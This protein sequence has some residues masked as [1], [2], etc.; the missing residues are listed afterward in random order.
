MAE[1][2]HAELRKARESRFKARWMFAQVFNYSVD[3]IEEIENGKQI[4][5][6]EQ[7]DRWEELTETPG[8]WHRWMCSNDDAYRKRYKDAPVP[9]STLAAFTLLKHEM[10]DVLEL[11]DSVEKSL[12]SGKQDVIDDPRLLEKYKKEL[13]EMMAAGAATLA[14]LEKS[15]P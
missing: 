10:K 13:Q 3:V 5:S 6:S 14:E 11:R 15:K 9:H 12:V 2:T 8:L 4:P 1:C 7:V